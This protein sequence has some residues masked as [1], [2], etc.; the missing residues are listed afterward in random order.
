MRNLWM[1]TEIVSLGLI[2][3][4]VCLRLLEHQVLLGR[5]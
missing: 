4:Q 5:T 1:S 3:R 2:F